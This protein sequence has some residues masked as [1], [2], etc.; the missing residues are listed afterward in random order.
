M[1]LVFLSKVVGVLF[2]LLLSGMV[3]GVRY[4][5]FS[6]FLA[7]GAFG[8]VYSASP[9]WQSQPMFAATIA[10]L[11][12]FLSPYLAMLLLSLERSRN[13]IIWQADHDGL[14]EA[15]NRRAFEREL[16]LVMSDTQ[17]VDTNF[18]LYMDLDKFKII[19]DKAGHAAGDG[20]ADTSAAPTEIDRLHAH[21][22]LR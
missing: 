12:L 11:I 14:T 3:F 4:L 20:D 2:G 6:S 1:V 10:G 15:L 13:K 17:T 21:R 19:N 18:L 9:Y 16:A 8:L 22:F 5:Y 7:L